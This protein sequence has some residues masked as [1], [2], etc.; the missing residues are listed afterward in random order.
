MA[1]RPVKGSVLLGGAFIGQCPPSLHNTSS[2][3][4]SRDE[5]SME[6]AY[7]K[8]ETTAIVNRFGTLAE[9]ESE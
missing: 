4:S 6:A 5:A 2:P 8:E 9:A 1:H 7:Q 3:I